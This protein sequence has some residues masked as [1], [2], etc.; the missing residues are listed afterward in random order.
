MS[1][2][3]EAQES[4]GRALCRQRGEDPDE[5]R[6]GVRLGYDRKRHNWKWAADEMIDLH[7]KLLVLGMVE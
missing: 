6:W 7:S 3:T 4:M 2:Y 5:L 1:G